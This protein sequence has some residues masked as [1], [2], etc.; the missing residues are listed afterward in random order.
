[1][2]PAASGIEWDDDL[3]DKNSEMFK[4]AAAAYVAEYEP[5]LLSK[6]FQFL[7]NFFE[8]LFNLKIQRGAGPYEEHVC[9]QIFE[10]CCS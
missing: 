5:I 1:M 3:E 10:L 4:K 8:M 7:V 2:L 6:F 9:F